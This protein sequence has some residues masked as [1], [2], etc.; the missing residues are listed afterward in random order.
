MATR[1]LTNVRAEAI[2][3]ATRALANIRAE[4]IRMATR[5]IAKVRVGLTVAEARARARAKARARA[6]ARITTIDSKYKYILAHILAIR[7]LGGNTNP[8]VKPF[9]L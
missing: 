6:R 8:M 5:A 7:L 4:A 2:R 3:I 1:A 9:H